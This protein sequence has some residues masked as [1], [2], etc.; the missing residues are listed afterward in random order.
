MKSVPVKKQF[1]RLVSGMKGDNE[2]RKV[3]DNKTVKATD[4]NEWKKV[5]LKYWGG[6]VKWI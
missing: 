3:I 4:V 5:K 2:E 6:K 1:N